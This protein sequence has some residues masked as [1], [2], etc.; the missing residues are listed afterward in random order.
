MEDTSVLEP[1]APVKK[2]DSSFVKW[3][4]KERDNKNVEYIIDRK[5]G[6]AYLVKQ[7]NVT[8]YDK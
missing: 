3:E 7:T 6:I 2:K 4:E 5:A 8:V 1:P